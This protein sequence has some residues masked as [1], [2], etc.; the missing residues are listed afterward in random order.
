MY[1]LKYIIGQIVWHKGTK[2]KIEAVRFTAG[3]ILY[4]LSGIKD[5]LKESEI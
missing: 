1:R 5:W 2:H 3:G 4:K